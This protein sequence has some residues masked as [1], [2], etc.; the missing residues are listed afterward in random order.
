VTPTAFTGSESAIDFT[1]GKY[2]GHG[3][4]L[5]G[6]DVWFKSLWTSSLQLLDGAVVYYTFN[7]SF[8]AMGEGPMNGKFTMAVGGGTLEGTVIGK[9]FLASDGTELQG[10]FNYVGIG[11]GGSIDGMKLTCSELYHEALDYTYAYG[12]L[13]GYIK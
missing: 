1:V 3:N 7:A 12:D 2:V 4:R 8:N 6:K 13:N 11:K 5:V 9:M 10:T